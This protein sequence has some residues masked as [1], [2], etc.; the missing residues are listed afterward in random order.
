MDNKNNADRL[1]DNAQ[2][3]ASET[4]GIEQKVNF[5]LHEMQCKMLTVGG[6]INTLAA[7]STVY[8]L[9]GHAKPTYLISWL[10]AVIAANGINISFASYYKYRKVPIEQIE[11]W[12]TGYHLIL[13][14]LALA[15]GCLGIIPI[16][17]DANYQLFAIAFLLV[18]LVGF[19]FGSITDFTAAL[20]SLTGLL[21]PY[22]SYHIFLGLHSILATELDPTLNLAFSF[23]L[24]SI[25]LFLLIA[26]YIGYRLTK[27]FFKLS[28]INV[29]LSKKLE[30]MNKILE[31]RV[32][33]RT[34]AL[35]ISLKEATYLATHDTLTN[36]PNRRLLLEHMKTAIKLA[37]QNQQKFAVIFFSL[38]ELERINDALGHKIGDLV[39]QNIAQR[40]QTTFKKII[41]TTFPNLNCEITLSRKDEFVILFQPI[42][43]LWE[44]EKIAG[45]LFS[46]LDAPIC[47]KKQTLKLT[48]SI[49]VSLYPRDG[50]D[51]KL[52]LMNADAAKLRAKEISGNSL[53]IYKPEINADISKRLE[54]ENDL[55]TAIQNNEFILHYQP[56]VDLKTGKICGME[57]LVRWQHPSLGFISP[58]LFIQLAESNGM[59]IPLGT[60]VLRTACA[61]TK[62][63][64]DQGFTSLKVA[65]NLSAKQLQQKNIIETISNILKET[66]L[67]PKYL[68]LELTETEAFKD[69][70]IPIIK[71]F[72]TMGVSLSIDDFGTGFSGLTNLKL[73]T[74]SKLKI[75]KSFI[76]D[77]AIN[78]DSKTIVENTI[79]L[80]KKLKIM[81]LA[82]GVETKEQLEFLQKHGC[83]MM[84]GYYFSK[85]LD[86]ENFAALL[87]EKRELLFIER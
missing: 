34:T 51:I 85:P 27:R 69:M 73:F 43:D 37:N 52:L 54:M 80:G 3:S 28:F 24:F 23:S 19:G 66:Q 45:L 81:V 72:K 40:L 68:E 14:L 20:I 59:I 44:I 16:N 42:I 21:F 65:V 4:A 12:R 8:V 33:E 64:H 36:L 70:S 76:E 26:C 58:A 35:Q 50:K 41:T 61:Q 22:M 67:N 15:W 32:Q 62:A 17:N 18:A 60:W 31:Q 57:A 87:E 53:N 5:E 47:T 84:Q 25:G 55:H 56:F 83:D 63:W 78:E 30:N 49:G 46:I 38:N 48:G 77:I 79:A 13:V 74:I 39:I 6:V 75:D 9:Y 29:A 1:L 11:S 82:E 10:I 2:L 71:Q 86:A 7:A